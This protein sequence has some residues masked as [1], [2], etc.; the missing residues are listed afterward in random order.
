MM[1]SPNNPLNNKDAAD[2][3]VSYDF[4]ALAKKD[5]RDLEPG[6]AEALAY[7]RSMVSLQDYDPNKVAPEDRVV[8]TPDHASLTI[9]ELANDENVED[10]LRSEAQ[11]IINNL[12][13]NEDTS[14]ADSKT[15][16]PKTDSPTKS[17]DAK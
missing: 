12:K 11:D 5:V 10:S 14:S 6:E 1:T 13:Q 7:H 9:G 4:N 16:T 15:V 2:P 17:A 8:E 3:S